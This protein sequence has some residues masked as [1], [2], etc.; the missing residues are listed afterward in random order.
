MNIDFD[1]NVPLYD[2]N[3]DAFDFE[4]F[5][6]DQNEEVGDFMLDKSSDQ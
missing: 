5:F 6:V 1:N 2:E 4:Y 3:G